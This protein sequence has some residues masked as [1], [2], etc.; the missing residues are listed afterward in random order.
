METRNGRTLLVPRESHG[1]HYSALPTLEYRTR[2][3][4][5]AYAHPGGTHVKMTSAAGFVSL[6]DHLQLI[7]D[8]DGRWWKVP[9]EVSEVG[10][11]EVTAFI[12]PGIAELPEW[13]PVDRDLLPPESGG[14]V[15]VQ[16][17]VARIQELRRDPKSLQRFPDD[18]PAPP[19]ERFEDRVLYDLLEPERRRQRDVMLLAIRRMLD[20][21][22]V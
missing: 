7:A 3:G 19:T 12:H 15:T 18:H 6:A 2:F 16:A 4:H 21:V 10:S 5:L 22:Y 20:C 14:R 9:R 11:V 8:Q 17:V 1:F 13:F